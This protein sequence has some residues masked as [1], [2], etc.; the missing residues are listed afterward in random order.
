MWGDPRAEDR[1]L[2]AIVSREQGPEPTE[3][4]VGAFGQRIAI[5][6]WLN[7]VVLLRCCGTARCLPALADLAGETDVV[8]NVRTALAL[9][10]E[11]LVVRHDDLPK[12]SVLAILDQLVATD[13]PDRVCKP[14]RSIDLLLKGEDQ[15]KLGNDIGSDVREDHGWQLHV[16][17]ARVRRALGQPV[18][19]LVEPWLADEHASIRRPFAALE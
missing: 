10:L 12:E 19:G 14:S 15:L 13:P 1:L 18:D 5:P 16:V 6:N 2:E 8:L 17:V 7:A 11:R 4:A 9:T 3:A